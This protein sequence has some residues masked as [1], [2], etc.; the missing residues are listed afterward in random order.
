ML[1]I[2]GQTFTKLQKGHLRFNILSQTFQQKFKLAT[3]L[4]HCIFYSAED[5]LVIVKYIYFYFHTIRFLVYIY[6]MSIM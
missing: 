3:N 6:Y 4:S 2:L 1:C 5:G